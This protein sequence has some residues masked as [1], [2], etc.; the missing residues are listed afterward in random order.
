MFLLFASALFRRGALSRRKLAML[1]LSVGNHI[2]PVG[3]VPARFWSFSAQT[4]SLMK[5][6]LALRFRLRA[7][8]SRIFSPPLS[9]LA[10]DFPYRPRLL[11]C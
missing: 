4:S 10:A 8:T 11:S 7:S 3:D 1:S 2:L 9:G 5:I 6:P